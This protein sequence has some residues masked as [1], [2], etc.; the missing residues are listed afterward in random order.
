MR[1]L[2][3]E[4]PKWVQQLLNNLYE[5]E[6]KISRSGDPGNASRNVTK[7]KEAIATEGVFYEDPFGQPFDETRT[8][9][10]VTISGGE[11]E[12]LRVVE[13]IKPII[14]IGDSSYS[15]VVQKGIVVVQAVG[16]PVQSDVEAVPAV[17]GAT[18]PISEPPP[19]T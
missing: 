6:N 1:P 14:R 15:R 13:V 19:N 18:D 10:E 11:T 4:I 3:A 12:N 17:P 2:A 16:T 5:V 8:D 9:L 7:M